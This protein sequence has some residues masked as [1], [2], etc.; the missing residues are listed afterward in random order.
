MEREKLQAHPL[1]K[2]AHAI[3]DCKKSLWLSSLQTGVVPAG[4]PDLRAKIVEID[5]KIYKST[6]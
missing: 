1:W 4:L 6:A 2:R 3:D 5:T